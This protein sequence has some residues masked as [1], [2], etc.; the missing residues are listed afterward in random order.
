MCCTT[1]NASTRIQHTVNA[2][3]ISFKRAPYACHLC[4]DKGMTS[5]DA[6][7][8]H[9]MR[10][11]TRL[12][13]TARN[14][15]KYECEMLGQLPAFKKVCAFAAVLLVAGFNTALKCDVGFPALLCRTKAICIRA[16][17]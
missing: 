12:A 10:M 11:H 6:T 2:G 9:A 13:A 16:I 17:I 15:F 5:A 3:A 4:A 7:R 14:N 8:A 1:S